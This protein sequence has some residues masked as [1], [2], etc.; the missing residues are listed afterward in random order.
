VYDAVGGKSR[1]G[2]YFNA[3]TEVDSRLTLIPPALRGAVLDRATQQGV[4]ATNQRNR[5]PGAAE[6]PN[7][8]RSNP[9][10]PTPDFA[11]DPSQ[12]LPGK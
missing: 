1:V 12:V 10:R 2:T 6:H 4:I 8:D 3:I 7:T 5:C 9:Y 11:C